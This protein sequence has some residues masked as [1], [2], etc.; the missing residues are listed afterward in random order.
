[1]NLESI[2]DEKAKT[3]AINS[4]YKS[5]N[6]LRK[7]P[8][9]LNKNMGELYIKDTSYVES[10]PIEDGFYK[11]EKAKK[12]IT[13][14]DKQLFTRLFAMKY[15][16][17][18]VFVQCHYDG[19]K[20]HISGEP[21]PTKFTLHIYDK[22]GRVINISQPSTSLPDFILR[23]Y[24]FVIFLHQ[25]YKT[26]KEKFNYAR[27]FK[28]LINKFPSENLF[29]DEVEI[30]KPTEEDIERDRKLA[31]NAPSTSAAALLKQITEKEKSNNRTAATNIITQTQDDKKLLQTKE[32]VNT[33]E[34]TLKTSSDEGKEISRERKAEM[35]SKAKIAAKRKRKVFKRR[36]SSEL[37]I[38][39]SSEELKEEINVERQRC[40]PIIGRAA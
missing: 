30:F 7:T 10:V 23:Q 13:P 34:N 15:K 12:K 18:I 5:L 21:T 22:E 14:T 36:T 19:K 1:M 6:A 9:T 17:K 20:D 27:K 35:L 32:A 37:N 25:D 26:E 38:D 16:L 40:C 4:Y 31:E 2:A 3:I 29:K 33:N 24:H 39:S 28:L 11:D 8:A